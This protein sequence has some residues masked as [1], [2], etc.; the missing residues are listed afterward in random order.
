MPRF[1]GG[2]VKS[3]PNAEVAGVGGKTLEHNREV[4]TPATPGTA[5]RNGL[6][7]GRSCVEMGWERT[8]YSGAAR[9]GSRKICDH[10]QGGHVSRGKKLRD[11][12]DGGRVRR[13]G[14]KKNKRHKRDAFGQNQ[15]CRGGRENSGR[16]D[17]FKKKSS[18]AERQYE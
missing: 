17:D 13:W 10:R 3:F 5:V 11:W 4:R 7:L 2:K 15:R 12:P 8:Y 16:G 14:G 6:S 9:K 1:P 18:F